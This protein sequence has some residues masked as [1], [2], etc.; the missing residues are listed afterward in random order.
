MARPIEFD[1]QEALEAAMKLFWRKGYDATS[2]QDLLSVMK[3]NRGSLYGAF[4][5]KK[6]LFIACLDRYN[7][8]V[9]QVFG[10]L[11]AKQ[12]SPLLSI[13][14]L[15]E[16]IALE[17]SDEELAVGCFFVN[18]IAELSQTE[19]DLSKIAV[20]RLEGVEAMLAEKLQLAVAQNQMPKDTAI[21]DYSRYLGSCIKGLRLTAK[22]NQNREQL[23]AIVQMMMQ[24]LTPMSAFISESKQ[25][26]AVCL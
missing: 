9:C 10:D 7:N 18:T 8:Y 25:S 4:G 1:K 26:E 16:F 6:S 2:I 17:M 15:F 14:G 21:D 20:E 11:L 12:A 22:H 5:D 19:M 13:Y 23:Y 3:I 24:G